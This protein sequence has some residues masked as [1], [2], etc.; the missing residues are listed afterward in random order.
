MN[1]LPGLFKLLI[2]S[3]LHFFGIFAG[4]LCFFINES[5]GFP[6]GVRKHCVR[7][8]LC[9]F[10]SLVGNGLRLDKGCCN[11]VF[12]CIV[13]FDNVTKRSELLFQLG[14][15]RIQLGIACID[16]L[17]KGVNLGR[18]IRAAAGRGKV[19]HFNLIRNHHF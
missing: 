13:F 3:L 17:H 14:V 18:F 5:L 9:A 16:P 15:F 19:L 2:G 11:G 4:V 8:V 12:A 10:N 7:G 6:F 1:F